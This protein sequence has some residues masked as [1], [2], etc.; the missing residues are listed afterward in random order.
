MFL[1]KEIYGEESAGKIDSISATFP[2]N[3]AP[4]DTAAEAEVADVRQK[5]IHICC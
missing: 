5:A 2:P 3:P 1:N 4:P